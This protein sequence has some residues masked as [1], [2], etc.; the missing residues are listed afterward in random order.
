MFSNGFRSVYERALGDEL[1]ALDPRLRAYFGAIPDGCR[2][3][4]AGV[5]DSAGL[6]IRLLRPVFALLARWGIAFPE[7]GADVLF[8][9]ENTPGAEGTLRATRTFH[10]PGR[11]RVMRDELRMVDGRLIDHLGV[12]GILEVVLDASVSE[13]GLRM[14]SRSLA[15]RAAGRR[16]PLPPVAK[17]ALEERTADDGMQHVD[18]RIRMPLLGEV[19]G[20]RGT[21]AYAMQ[22]A[23]RPLSA[24]A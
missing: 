15:L 13:G 9:I 24:R 3:V 11:T 10:F 21:F 23:V 18:V 1:D 6:R 17:V 20:Y 14:E 5:F 19:Y 4:G 8:E 16:I 12:R 7:S 22:P 2:G